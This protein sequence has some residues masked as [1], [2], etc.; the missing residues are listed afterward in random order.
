M[1]ADPEEISRTLR[2]GGGRPA[3]MKWGLAFVLILAAVAAWYVYSAD[4]SGSAVRY[5]TEDVRRDMLTVTV[6]ATGTVQP[7][8]QV[9]ISSELSGMINE[10]LV[11]YNDLVEEG[12]VLAKLDT[13]K[14][15]AQVANA[16]A[17]LAAAKARVVQAKGNLSESQTK[18]ASA[19]RLDAT[20]YATRNEFVSAQIALEGA[21]ASLAIAE[22]ERSLAEANL[23][24]QRADLE[25]AEIRSP[26]RGIVLKRDIDPGQTV[27]ASLSAPILFTIAEDLTRMELQV[28]IDE[29]D[30][31][32]VA[33]GNE[34]TFT[35][36]AY[37]DK[38]FPAT[39]TSVRYAPESTDN[40]VTYKA[41]LSVDNSD[42][43][44]RPGM[45][46]S[47][48]IVVREV[49]DAL[50]VPNAALRYV[51][52]QTATQQTDGRSGSG[53][54]GLLM[55]R[56]PRS[57]MSGAGQEGKAVWVLR[58]ETPERVA[59]TAGTSNGRLTEIV[60]GDI[61]EGDRVITD[62]TGGS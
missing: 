29:A 51:P 23:S 38:T 25:K 19:K 8:K 36:D 53:L 16:E 4:G 58:G 48:T 3:W 18:H 27:A 12:T 49:A 1:P 56:P 10:V 43:D 21:Q 7:T 9:D 5:Q 46:A 22:A 55:P 13:T 59:V 62:Q 41:V 39:I 45:T 57:G 6:A 50:L 42:L 24:L 35:V 11:D 40:V 54:L 37:A 32:R 47:A 60:S 33:V 28:D 34:A 14:L 17:S 30:I 44:L 15:E 61:E 52:P 26:I 31:G 20:G 2:A